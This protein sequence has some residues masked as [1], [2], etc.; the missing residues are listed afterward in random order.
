GGQPAG[1]NDLHAVLGT[2]GQGTGGAFPDDGGKHRAV[3]LEVEIEMTRGG[4]RDAADLA[5]HPD[6]A[7]LA[8]DHPAHRARDFGDGEF[9]NIGAGLWSRVLDD[10]HWPS[11]RS[12]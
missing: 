1:G 2:D 5:A 11:G 4:A 6:A 12:G 10:V 3:V 8:L 9:G 7:E